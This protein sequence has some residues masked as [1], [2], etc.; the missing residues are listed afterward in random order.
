VIRIVRSEWLKL[1]TTMVPLTLTAAALAINAL[2]I[3]ATFL[4]RGQSAP[5]LNTGGRLVSPG[6]TVPHTVEQ[7][8]NLIGTGFQG[9]IFA[10]LLGVLCITTEFRHKT[11]TTS[12]LITPRRREFIAGK[13]LI[14]AIVGAA[15][16]A[17]MLATS[18]VAGGITLHARGGSFD[19]LVHQ[20]PA[21]APGLILVFALSAILGIGI[22]AILN[23]QVAAIVATLG[24]FFI[25]NQIVVGLIHGAER[26]VPTGAATATARLTRGVNA[27]F[28]LLTWW[29]GAILMLGYG[30][31]L[32]T[33]GTLTLSKRDLT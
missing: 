30:L 20:I 11:I 22:G 14:A 24:W 16:G 28:G 17:L 33:A 23:N 32:A 4:D 29:Q 15:L 10:V 18:I 8:R 3:V 9:Y 19:A 2:L 7:L 5:R 27:E 13:V 1:R 12:M 25:L 21:V 6:Y 26:W 31:T